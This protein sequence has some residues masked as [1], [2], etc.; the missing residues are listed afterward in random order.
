MEKM[1]DRATR[2]L[3]IGPAGHAGQGAN[4]RDAVRSAY[5]VEARTFSYSS[6]WFGNGTPARFSEGRDV[7]LPYPYWPYI[8]FRK[9]GLDRVLGGVTDL[10]WDGFLTLRGLP[11]VPLFDRDLAWLRSK[12]INVGLLAHGSDI[13]DPELH[14]ATISHSYF[15]DAE[16]SWVQE[17][18]RFSSRNREFARRSGVRTFVSTPDLLRELPRAEWVPVVVAP[19]WRTASREVPS[20]VKPKVLHLPSRAQPPIK[21]TLHI[22]PALERLERRGLIQMVRATPRTNSAMLE[23][24]RSVDI[25]VDQ[26]GTGSYG[27]ASAEAMS[28]GRVVVGDLSHFV[29]S[30]VTDEIPIV[31]SGADRVEDTIGSLIGNQEEF[32]SLYVSGIEYARKYHFGVRSAGVIASFMGI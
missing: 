22:Q 4:W 31:Q 18:G 7:V 8:P 23:L 25:V 2:T 26:V 13:R 10:L 21:G 30:V 17:R 5:G 24:V 29:R 11:R 15:H 6:A 14:I 9:N 32:E 3:A 20:S 28:Q 27:T 1:I 12:G 19:H 16:R